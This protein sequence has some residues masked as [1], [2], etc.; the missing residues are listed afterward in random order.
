MLQLLH[1]VTPPL[2]NATFEA[3]FKCLQDDL[4]T[5]HNVREAQEVTQ[6]TKHEAR[7]DRCDA[8]QTFQK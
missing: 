6:H 7:E 3:A 2:S 1:A 8:E 5:Q 4:S